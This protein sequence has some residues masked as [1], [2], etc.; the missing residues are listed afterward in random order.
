MMDCAQYR[1]TLLADPNA[2]GPELD[3]HLASCPDCPA[4]RERLQRFE[5]RLARALR[6][7]TDL[8]A[9]ERGPRGPIGHERAAPL[10]FAP[11]GSSPRGMPVRR[12]P[13]RWLAMAASVVVA[14][15][16]AGALWLAAPHPSLAAAVVAHM[17]GEPEAWTSTTPVAPEDLAP[18]LAG[19]HMTLK[20]DAGMVSYAQSCLFRGHHVPHLVV[21]TDMGPVT[22]MVLVHESIATS[23]PFD[24]EG[25]RGVIVPVP[26]H[27][28]LAVLARG[29]G[30]D[31]AAIESVAAR[32]RSAISWTG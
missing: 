23:R 6:L 12:V 25:Y 11:P 4:Y 20:P 27:G 24:E 9:A 8:G 19:A 22:V 7:D 21:Q 14:L 29:Q 18:V 13:T 5:G 31:L 17:A 32:V 26:G 16:A 10:G 28:S 30:A 2:S 3:A 15:V 1:R